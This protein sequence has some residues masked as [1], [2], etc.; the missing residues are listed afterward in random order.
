MSGSSSDIDYSNCIDVGHN[1]SYKLEKCISRVY[2]QPKLVFCF[3][4]LKGPTLGF[5]WERDIMDALFTH[6]CWILKSIAY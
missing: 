4:I 1:T 2:D 5:P 3:G 6:K